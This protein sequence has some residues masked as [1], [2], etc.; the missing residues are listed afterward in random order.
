MDESRDT[1]IILQGSWYKKIN[2][3]PS[4]ST[5]ENCLKK[6]LAFHQA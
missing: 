2:Q 3:K 6:S 5:R 1:Q 4:L